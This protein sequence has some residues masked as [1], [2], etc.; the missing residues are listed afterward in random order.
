MAANSTKTLMRHYASVSELREAVSAGM[1]ID[2]NEHNRN[3]H[4]QRG[5][6]KSWHGIE[7]GAAAVK[8]AMINGYQEG[9]AMIKT[10][11]DAMAVKLPR[12]VGIARKRVRS[13]QGDELD[14]H[15]VNRGDLSRS[16]ESCKR[17]LKTGN[18]ALRLCIDI[19][20]NAAQNATALAWR[21]VAGICLSEIMRKAGYNIEV[22]A[23]CAVSDFLRH[24]K[25]NGVVSVTVKARNAT[26]DIAQLAATVALTGFFRVYMF[27]ALI[28]LAEDAGKEADSSLGHYLE[29]SGVMPAAPSVTQLFVAGSV[30]NEASAIKWVKEALFL[31]QGVRL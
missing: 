28:K 19:G 10:F 6:S 31:L 3:R 29:S 20:G 15:A 5:C 7:G 2:N 4:M 18:G 1:L 22:V 13:D 24:G 23:C 21:G 16:W 25:S 8:L 11:H 27:S 17:Q 14:I 26:T 12:A 30:M 9:E